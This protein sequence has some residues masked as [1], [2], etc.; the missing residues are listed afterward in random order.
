L[1]V[2]G[3]PE[4]YDGSGD[5]VSCVVLA[6]AYAIGAI[7]TTVHHD[8]DVD[9][10]DILMAIAMANLAVDMGATSALRS[11]VKSDSETAGSYLFVLS[12]PTP[13]I[14][15]YVLI[16][17]HPYPTS[18]RIFSSVL[19]GA[20]IAFVLMSITAINV[21]GRVAEKCRNPWVYYLSAVAV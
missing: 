18:V 6:I 5:V 4:E 19:W 17:R 8:P 21:E 16:K 15:L 1:F 7:F 12:T 10:A 11:K 13:V 14:F 3:W 20:Q 2:A 9:D